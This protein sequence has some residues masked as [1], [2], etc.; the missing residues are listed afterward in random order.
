VPI[1]VLGTSFL[2]SRRHNVTTTYPF[3]S[4]TTT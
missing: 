1:W 2:V 3:P 4:I